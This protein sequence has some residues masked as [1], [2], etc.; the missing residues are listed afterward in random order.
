MSI[1]VGAVFLP[2]LALSVVLFYLIPRHAEATKV[3]LEKRAERILS[4]IE[5]ELEKSAQKKAVEAARLLGPELLLE[6]RPKVIHAA[7]KKAG[8]GG[9][10]FESLH[11][12]VS[13]PRVGW[14][15]GTSAHELDL[16]PWIVASVIGF[17][18]AC[19]DC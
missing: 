11:L 8:F 2:S 10:V 12:E 19:H 5:K 1:F 3:T 9:K 13:T 18:C 15:K 7:L 4:W 17:S 14:K 16:D 6:G